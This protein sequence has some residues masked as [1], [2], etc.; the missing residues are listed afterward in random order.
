MTDQVTSASVTAIFFSSRHMFRLFRVLGFHADS[1]L[2]H[3]YAC[4]ENDVSSLSYSREDT[5]K[6]AGGKDGAVTA[7]IAAG[8]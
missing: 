7:Y 8:P 6:L 3:D 4:D 1:P 2:F 5:C